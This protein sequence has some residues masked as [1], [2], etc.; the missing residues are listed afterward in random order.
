L[1]LCGYLSFLTIVLRYI[2]VFVSVPSS[3]VPSIV[4]FEV[5]HISLSGVT[6]NFWSVI[7]A[8]IAVSYGLLV[9]G[10]YGTV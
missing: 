1:L 9:S 3:F 10:K 4:I 6:I 2:P 5:T 8:A 7:S